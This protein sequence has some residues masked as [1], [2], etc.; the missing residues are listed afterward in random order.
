[1]KLLKNVR[2]GYAISG[3]GARTT[4]DHVGRQSRRSQNAGMLQSVSSEIS[5]AVLLHES[6]ALA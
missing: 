4:D 5:S 3:T 1:M 6:E 2:W